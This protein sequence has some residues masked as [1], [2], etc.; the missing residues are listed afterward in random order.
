MGTGAIGRQRTIWCN[1]RMKLGSLIVKRLF[2][3]S[4]LISALAV[5]WALFGPRERE[6]EVLCAPD[7]RIDTQEQAVAFAKQLVKG[8]HR[9]WGFNTGK[10][11]LSAIEEH[12]KCCSASY[13]P[14]SVEVEGYGWYVSIQG[15]DMPYEHVLEFAR[16]G[17]VAYNGGIYLGPP[18]EATK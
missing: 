13:G 4:C 17:R 12:S 15:R 14:Y 6:V 11:Y 8:H 18:K 2:L 9:E 1:H 10:D 5:V 7:K 3:V 16:C